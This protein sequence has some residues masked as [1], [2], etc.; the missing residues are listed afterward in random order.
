M[1]R[2]PPIKFQLNLQAR[3]GLQKIADHHG[4]GGN[5]TSANEVA[6]IWATAGAMVRPTQVY[7]ALA[8]LKPYQR[9]SPLTVFRMPAGPIRPKK[10]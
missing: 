10:S 7:Q 3:T 5:D 2:N 8:A 9:T 1:S 4:I 6:R